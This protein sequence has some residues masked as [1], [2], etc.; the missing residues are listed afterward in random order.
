MV[1]YGYQWSC[2]AIYDHVWS[3]TVMHGHG[4]GHAC[5]TIFMYGHV[6]SCMVIFGH[7]W[8]C[9]WS[10]I[11][12]C[13]CVWV[14]M[15]IIKTKMRRYSRFVVMINLVVAFFVVNVVVDDVEFEFV[16]WIVGGGGGLDRLQ[17]HFYF[18]PALILFP[19]LLP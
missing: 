3:C 6:L 11:V 9:I 15:V 12:T 8:L 1:M 13:G 10:C 5:S 14:C 4:H 19:C 18:K 2:M 7:V 16:L 17:S